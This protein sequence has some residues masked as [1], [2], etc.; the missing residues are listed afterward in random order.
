MIDNAMGNIAV[1]QTRN[2]NR[3]AIPHAVLCLALC[4]S[5]YGVSVVAAAQ[6]AAILYD[7]GPTRPLS[8]YVEAMVPL[9]AAS[10]SARPPLPSKPS[11][12]MPSQAANTTNPHN[13]QNPLALNPPNQSNAQPL[14]RVI[15][16]PVYPVDT[17]SLNPGPVEPRRV[18]LPQLASAPFFLIGND[19]LSRDWLAHYSVRL[20][21][22][23]AAGFLVKAESDAELQ[24]IRQLAPGI[25]ITP[26]DGTQLAKTLGLAH[27][28]VLVT[29]GLIEQ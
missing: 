25:P 12:Q 17:P 24:S 13:A 16:S 11:S 2:A 23:G 4:A 10:L 15:P 28:P 6:G 18:Q 9:S 29:A 19:P 8:D 27:Y 22:L 5:L 7:Q 1:R 3:L 20:A 26:L 14:N 21:A